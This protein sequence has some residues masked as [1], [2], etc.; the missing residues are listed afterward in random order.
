[1]VERRDMV[2]SQRFDVVIKETKN[3][4]YSKFRDKSG[5]PSGLK[6]K[7]LIAQ[8]IQAA[9]DEMSQE[10]DQVKTGT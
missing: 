5:W 3:I 9:L 4:I 2:A 8:R 7:E 10:S 1:V 6:K